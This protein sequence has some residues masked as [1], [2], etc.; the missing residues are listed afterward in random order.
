MAKSETIKIKGKII[1]F[2]FSVKNKMCS[3][4]LSVPGIFYGFFGYDEDKF[5][6]RIET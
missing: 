5:S 1:V 2:N 3:K 4:W 6:T